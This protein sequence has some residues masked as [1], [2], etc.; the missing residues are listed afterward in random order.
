MSRNSFA[1]SKVNEEY[2]NED[3]A[4]R[5][6]YA[7]KGHLQSYFLTALGHNEISQ[8]LFAMIPFHSTLFLQKGQHLRTPRSLY[9]PWWR[10]YVKLYKTFPA[11]SICFLGISPRKHCNSFGVA[12]RTV[13]CNWMN[14]FLVSLK[15][16]LFSFTWASWKC[17]AKGL[18]WH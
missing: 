2:L 1:L 6:Y 5:C 8:S 14:C 12:C 11:C 3:L 7:L 16:S 18:Q 13:R 17:K 15:N 9:W 4:D 10:P